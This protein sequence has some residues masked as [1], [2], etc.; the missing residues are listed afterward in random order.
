M[1][2]VGTGRGTEPNRTGS[3]H[4]APEKRRPNRVE[5]GNIFV[6]TEPNRWTLEKSGPETNRTEAAPSWYSWQRQTDS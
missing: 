1:E 5:P 6:R 2:P 3:S 4:D